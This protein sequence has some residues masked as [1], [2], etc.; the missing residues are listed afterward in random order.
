M[1]LEWFNNNYVE[2]S[3]SQTQMMREDRHFHEDR[4]FLLSSTINGLGVSLIEESLIASEL[5]SGAVV[6][7]LKQTFD[8]SSAYHI[9]I[10]KS[11]VLTRSAK[12]FKDWL[13]QL[14]LTEML[15]GS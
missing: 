12:V 10:P 15:P 2:L 7:P 6:N 9:V 4:H 13:L 3:S 5:R 14:C 8:S 11:A 1:W